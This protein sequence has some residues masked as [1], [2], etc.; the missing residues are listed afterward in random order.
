MIVPD[1]RVN[2]G[3]DE[4]A[5]RNM[6]L[7]DTVNTEAFVSPKNDIF[8]SSPNG[9]DQIQNM[10]N[11]ERDANIIHVSVI[12]EGFRWL[13]KT[14]FIRWWWSWLLQNLNQARHYVDATLLLMKLNV[15]RNLS[16]DSSAVLTVTPQLLTKPKVSRFSTSGLGVKPKNAA[17]SV[18]GKFRQVNFHWNRTKNNFIS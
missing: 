6:A 14:N 16:H 13:L 3:D 17:N 12:F 18:N 9:D 15:T 7:E 2:A 4:I 11:I 10:P 5:P 1:I 8:T